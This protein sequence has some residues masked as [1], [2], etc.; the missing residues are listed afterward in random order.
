MMRK[1][2]GV[3]V[4]VVIAMGAGIG[5]S[6]LSNLFPG[7]V[8]P[9]L[10]VLFALVF[11]VF[12]TWRILF[13]VSH[14]R[15]A[16]RGNI[17]L[18]QGRFS[19]AID[20]MKEGGRPRNGV[21]A[22]NLAWALLSLWRLDEA[23]EAYLKI[24]RRGAKFSGLVSIGMPGLA[25]TCALKGKTTE[26]HR[27]LQDA[28]KVG[29]GGTGL[30]TVARAVLT[31]RAGRWQETRELLRRY[32]VTLLGGPTG[33]LADAL[34]AWAVENTTGERRHVDP[35]ALFGE[36]SS[37]GLKNAWPELVAFVEQAPKA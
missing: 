31:A 4:I 6:R 18:Q 3:F 29:G 35:V 24:P 26:A 1:L 34:S 11:F 28:E 33:A 30:C 7:L 12:F 16:N 8:R 14:V 32:E 13:A 5:L 10:P 17:L 9:W 19:E 37:A 21:L 22:N 23:E 36:G 15:L 25:L 2:G 20:T 27:W